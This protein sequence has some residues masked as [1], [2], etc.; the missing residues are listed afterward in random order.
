MARL[1]AP[2]NVCNLIECS[3]QLKLVSCRFTC[4]KR[5][6]SKCL[7]CRLLDHNETNGRERKLNNMLGGGSEICTA[8]RH[9]S[10]CRIIASNERLTRQQTLSVRVFPFIAICILCGRTA[11]A[12]TYRS[13]IVLSSCLANLAIRA[14]V[15][16]GA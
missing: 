16:F 10:A 12:I 7:V 9:D 6:S 11:F 5:V 15:A 14:R 1:D 3:E 2:S 4:L 13:T 8:P